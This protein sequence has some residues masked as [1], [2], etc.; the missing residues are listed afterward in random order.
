M[1][2]DRV[3]IIIVIIIMT[4]CNVFVSLLR[5]FRYAYF[6]CSIV[7]SHLTEHGAMDIQVLRNGLALITSVSNDDSFGC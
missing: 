4:L 7:M 5:Y 3:I 2:S 1:L 6:S